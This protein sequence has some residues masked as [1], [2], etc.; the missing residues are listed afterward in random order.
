MPSPVQVYWLKRID[1]SRLVRQR[2]PEVIRHT[3]GLFGGAL[4]CAAVL[5]LCAW[6]H[7]QFI[8]TG[9]QLEEL[10]GRHEQV[11]DWNRTLRVEQ[12]ALLDPMRIDVLA[13]SRLGLEVPAAGQVV[14]VGPSAPPARVAVLARAEKE[15]SAGPPTSVSLAD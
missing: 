5:L 2:D 3:L 11:L 12:A 7:F 10:Q 1:N 8:H 15:E 4:V 6:Q 9:Y 13:R 14:P